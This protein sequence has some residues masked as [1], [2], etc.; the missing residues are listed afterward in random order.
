[1]RRSNRNMACRRNRSILHKII[2]LG[3][4]L[5]FAPAH[6]INIEFDYTYDTR[7][8]FTDQS[9]GNPIAERRS[10]L[11][12]AA[13]YY[14]GF[15][16]K[17]AAIAPQPGDTWSVS[18]SHPSLAGPAVTLTDISIPED[19][20][21]V[22]VGG[23]SSAPGVLGFSGVGT[24]LVATGSNQFVD[25]VL[26]RQQ[27]NG[28]GAHAEDYGIWEGSIWFNANNDWY[29]GEDASGLT[30]NHPDF[31]TT[32]IHELGHILGYGE[33]ASWYAQIDEA[34]GT[35][36]GASSV[37]AYGKP[38]QLDQYHMHW[39]SGTMSTLN[40]V[41][42]NTLMDPSTAKGRREL[43]TVLDYAGFRDIGWQVSPV[44]APSEWAML[45]GG[46]AVVIFM[47]RRREDMRS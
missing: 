45:L 47:T 8:F 6:A 14:S 21:R 7:G 24:N 46:L 40:G 5:A 11:E 10:L 34:S 35:F 28:T 9:T 43:P 20:I 31:L 12:T 30:P 27:A 36:L 41:M 42:Q 33:A 18:F 1:M 32:V 2:W 19:T 29:F 23:S 16:D 44:P 4:M 38:V 15:S 3:G 25:S 26:T 13:S 22:Y 37:A 39:A 17:L